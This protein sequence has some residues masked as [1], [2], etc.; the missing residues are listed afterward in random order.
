M[1]K[2]ETNQGQ[3]CDQLQSALQG[4]STINDHDA[5]SIATSMLSS[6]SMTEHFCLHFVGPKGESDWLY[7]KTMA[8]ASL[9]IFACPFVIYQ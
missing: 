7:Q 2:I 5:P 6:K 3:N 8:G 1:V 9:H 4:H